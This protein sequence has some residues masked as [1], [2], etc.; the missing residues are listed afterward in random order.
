MTPPSLAR[1]VGREVEPYPRGDQR[2]TKQPREETQKEDSEAKKAYRIEKKQEQTKE[3]WQG[4]NT[5]EENIKMLGWK[6]TN[7]KN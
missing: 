5:G 6:V 1:R 2:S 7:N 3:E 4:K